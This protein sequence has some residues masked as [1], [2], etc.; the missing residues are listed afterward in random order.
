MESGSASSWVHC[1]L[2][3][4]ATRTARGCSQTNWGTHRCTTYQKRHSNPALAGVVP[5]AHSAHMRRTCSRAQGTACKRQ[6]SSPRPLLLPWRCRCCGVAAGGARAARAAGA[7][8]RCCHPAPPLPPARLPRRRTVSAQ[9]PWT[10]ASS[11]A[12]HA[13]PVISEIAFCPLIAC[14]SSVHTVPSSETTP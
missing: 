3:Q 7:P 4:A 10:C 14:E 9:C 5:A 2:Y 1:M 13:M 11:C 8:G 6:N 12:A